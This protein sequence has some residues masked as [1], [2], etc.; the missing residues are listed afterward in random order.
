MSADLRGFMAPAAD[1]R[2]ML[3]WRLIKLQSR[4]TAATRARDAEQAALQAAQ[5]ELRASL[6]AMRPTHAAAVHPLHLE[7]VIGGICAESQ[8]RQAFGLAHEQLQLARQDCKDCQLRLLGLARVQRVAQAAFIA[9]AQQS[10]ASK[11]DAD[12]LGR[13]AWQGS[14]ERTE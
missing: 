4:R 1:A 10:S 9:Q 6:A 12:V 5:V 13:S 11:L 7:R 2:Q 8:A 14:Q 3:E